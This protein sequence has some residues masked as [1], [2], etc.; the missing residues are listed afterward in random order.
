MKDNKISINFDNEHA[1][2][3]RKISER[4]KW[5]DK[6]IIQTI[7]DHWYEKFTKDWKKMVLGAM[8][9]EKE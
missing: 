2:K 3:F 8:G 9:S 6:V 1:E 4:T 5:P 7:V